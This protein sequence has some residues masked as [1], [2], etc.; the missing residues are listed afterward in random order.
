MRF[1]YNTNCVQSDGDSINDMLDTAVAIT[2]VTFRRRCDVEDWEH[3]MGYVR[4]RRHGLTLARDYHVAYY[5]SRYR[6]QPCYY[7]VHSAI[8]HVFTPGPNNRT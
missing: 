7:A 8:E 1:I 6:G 2:L 5:K 3:Q 4:D